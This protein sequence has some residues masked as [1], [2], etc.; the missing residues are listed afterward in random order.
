MAINPN[1]VIVP[2]IGRSIDT[3][4][5]YVD[6]MQ[7]KHA[8]GESDCDLCRKVASHETPPIVGGV[9]IRLVNPHFVLL[10]NDFPYSYYDGHAVTAHHLLLPRRH[11][12]HDDLLRDTEL[13]RAK[14]DAEAEVMDLSCGQ[15]HVAME[16]SS[17][18]RASSIRDHD[19]KHFMTLGGLIVEQYFSISNQQNDVII[20]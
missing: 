16:R 19:H 15:Y 1:S 3:Q 18:S 20:R 7:T 10:G 2:A 17:S 8:T 4:R 9:A 12:D 5:A 11:I 6:H 14:A 13:R